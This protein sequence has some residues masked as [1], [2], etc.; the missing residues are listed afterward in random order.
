[1][2]TTTFLIFVSI[3]LVLYGSVN[4]YIFLRGW[5]AF[6][7]NS[8]IKIFYVTFFLIISL[9]YIAARIF[10]RFLPVVLND[11]LIWI[12]SFW[13]GAIL[14]FVLIIILLDIT[15]LINNSFPFY[16]AF[17]TFD[18]AKTKEIIAIFSILIVIVL[19]LYG[20]INAG[21]PVTN[22]IDISINKNVVEINELNIAMVS[23]IHLGNIVG[24]ER[25]DNIVKKINEL[26]PDIVLLPGDIVDE[27]IAPVMKNDLGKSL[28]NIKSK[29][30]TF[31]T[32]GNHEYIGGVEPA[33]NYL[34][35]HNIT[36]LRDS[37][38]KIANS[39]YLAGR[40]DR[41]ISR[42]T[43]KKR[44]PL[45]ELLKDIDMTLPIVLMDHQPFALEDAVIN[46]VDVQVSGHTHNGQLFPINFITKLI[47]EISSGYLKK[48]KTHFYVSNG[49]GTWGPPIRIGNQPEI[50]NII[51]K[52]KE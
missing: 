51:L 28:E 7:Q 21:N 35:E 42:F 23:D 48:E 38:I 32:T 25:L 49:V 26:N 10:E 9:S 24:K 4:F 19:L 20:Y 52:F 39:F 36:F 13:L 45:K 31:A 12:G 16:P 41:D 18:Y 30:G 6:S 37:V 47:Y 14:Y 46:G 33:V 29:Y 2:K 15:R 50:V 40:E 11:I 44:K 17:A 8:A 3:V 22:K 43:N 5:Q 34:S 1:M 27:D